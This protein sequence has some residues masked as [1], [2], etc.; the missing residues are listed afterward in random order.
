MEEVAV[1]LAET[2]EE[3]PVD[4]FVDIVG[5]SQDVDHALIIEEINNFAIHTPHVNSSEHLQHGLGKI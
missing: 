4:D 1:E 3:Q 5:E 2:L